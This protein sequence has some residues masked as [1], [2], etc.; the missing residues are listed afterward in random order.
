MGADAPVSGDAEGEVPVRRFGGDGLAGGCLYG[1]ED[2]QG[3][4]VTEGSLG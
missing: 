4:P 2:I 1:P 3:S